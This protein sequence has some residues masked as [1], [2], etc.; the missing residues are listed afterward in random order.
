MGGVTSENLHVWCV[1]CSKCSNYV[2][3]EAYVSHVTSVEQSK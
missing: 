1:T 2:A 3:S